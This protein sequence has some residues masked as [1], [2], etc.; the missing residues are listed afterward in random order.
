MNLGIPPALTIRFW[1][2]VHTPGALIS[3]SGVH[4]ETDHTFFVIGVR[5]NRLYREQGT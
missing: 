1:A 2:N 5:G 3:A 4:D